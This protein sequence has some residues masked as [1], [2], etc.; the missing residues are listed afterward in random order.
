MRDTFADKVK[1]N[2][3]LAPAASEV[4]KQSLWMRLRAVPRAK[5]FVKVASLLATCGLLAV[6]VI[7]PTMSTTT[8][9]ETEWSEFSQ[10]ETLEEVEVYLEIAGAL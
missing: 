4:F 6:L 10:D 7:G 3:P 8:E 2:R 9:V 5:D 1:K